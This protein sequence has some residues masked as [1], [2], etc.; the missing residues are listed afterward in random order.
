M[1]NFYKFCYILPMYDS[2]DGKSKEGVAGIGHLKYKGLMRMKSL[3]VFCL[4][5]TSKVAGKME[6]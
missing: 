4:G 6:Y 3:Y 1:E 2:E 5:R